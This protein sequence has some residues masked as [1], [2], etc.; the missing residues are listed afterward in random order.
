MLS[1]YNLK[2]NCES[3]IITLGIMIED[4]ETVDYFCAREIPHFNI[5]MKVFPQFISD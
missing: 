1:V 4:K 5:K 2:I 3:G